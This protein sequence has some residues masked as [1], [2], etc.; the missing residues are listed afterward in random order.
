M[1]A[2]DAYAERVLTCLSRPYSIM[3]RDSCGI[4]QEFRYIP[5]PTLGECVASA[6]YAD[7]PEDKQE[8]IYEKFLAAVAADPVDCELLR[9]E[10]SAAAAASVGL[11]DE[12]LEFAAGTAYQ[13]NMASQ[14][15]AALLEQ[16]EA[17]EEPPE[18]EA[19]VDNRKRVVVREAYDLAHRSFSALSQAGM[20]AGVM[21][22]CRA[23]ASGILDVRETERFL[24]SASGA[25]CAP[26]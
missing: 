14:F 26:F 13:R 9:D 2:A 10:P 1:T 19:D 5:G 22:I 7:L 24:R 8:Y 25:A 4:L 18:Q 17:S 12:E 16:L 23:G 15:S 6:D 21:A 20:L 11:T 3:Y